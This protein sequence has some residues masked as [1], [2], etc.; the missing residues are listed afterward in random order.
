MKIIKDNFECITYNHKTGN[1]RKGADIYIYKE[2]CSVCGDAF[3]AR[4]KYVNGERAYA[5]CCCRSCAHISVSRSVEHK[6]KISKAH[7][8]KPLSAEHKQKISK[9]HMDKPLSAEHK[10][11]ISEALRGRE[12]SDEHKR[13]LSEFQ[14]GTKMSTERR[15]NLSQARMGK[16]SGEESPR[17]KG[18]VTSLDIPLYDTYG[19]KLAEFEEVRI[20]MLR[21]GCVVYKTLQVRCHNSSCRKWFVPKR[22]SVRNRL[23]VF[24]G[25]VSGANDFYCLEVCKSTC[26]TYNQKLYPKEYKSN[27]NE[28]PYTTD[29]YQLYRKTVLE[30]ENYICEY[31]GE[32]AKEVHHER[33][34]KTDP[35]FVVDPD[36][37]HAVCKKCHMKYGHKTGTE[38]S[39]G[40]LAKKIC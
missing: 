1:F 2:A 28:K 9:A 38:C 24:Y 7:M 30:R 10:Q 15:K 33:S 32:R 36:Y 22:T 27:Q 13:N 19:L 5:D 40:N 39:T 4:K 17:Y 23:Q 16:Y 6:Q 11:K 20:Y 31:C 26:P 18:G 37:G 29:Q 14:K 35:M 34:Q 21:I 8:G 25:Q 3:L 12:F